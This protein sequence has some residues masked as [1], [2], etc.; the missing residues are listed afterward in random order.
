MIRKIAVYLGATMP[1]DHSYVDAVAELGRKMA[2]RGLA[3]V[4]GGS[5]EG[6]MTVLADAVLGHGG[7]A[8]GV[9]TKSLPPE[10]LYEG[11]TETVITENLAERKRLMLE[12]ADAVVALPGS[13][14]TWDELFDALEASKIEMINGRAPKPIAILNVNGFY[15]GIVELMERSVLDGFTTPQCARLLCLANTVDE[16]LGKL[17]AFH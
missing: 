5:R 10:F 11:L 7:R 12:R 15:N 6:T 13:F 14:G 2:E 17:M 16:L 1:A 9:F 3:L 8:I 4:F